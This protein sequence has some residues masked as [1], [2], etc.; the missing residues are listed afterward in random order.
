[1]RDTNTKIVLTAFALLWAGAAS[2]LAA[3]PDPMAEQKLLSPAEIK[4]GPAPGSLPPGAEAAVVYGDPGKEGQFAMRLKFP[5]GY[6]IP[7]HTHPAAEI[8]T[9]ISGTL[10]LGMGETADRG[11]AKALPAGS[12]AALPAGHAHFAGTDE[13]TVVQLNSAGPW[14]IAY[15][16]P[17]DEPRQKTQ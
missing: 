13:E 2:A 17:K 7:P 16:N 1:M 15:V 8:V 9:V 11:K 5:K 6:R 12:F 10:L 3:T 14:G 4:W